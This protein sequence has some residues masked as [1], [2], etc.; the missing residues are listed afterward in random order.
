M[1]GLDIQFDG[2]VS[3]GGRGLGV[4]EHLCIP[5]F[6]EPTVKDGK[7]RGF[8]IAYMSVDEE[9]WSQSIRYQSAFVHTE[10][11]LKRTQSL[12][13]TVRPQHKFRLTDPID[14]P[15]NLFG[16]PFRITID[17]K[18]GRDGKDRNEMTG[19]NVASDTERKEFIDRLR[20]ATKREQLASEI[21]RVISD[22]NSHNAKRNDFQSNFHAPLITNDGDLEEYTTVGSFT[23]AEYAA[24]PKWIRILIPPASLAQTATAANTFSDGTGDDYEDGIPF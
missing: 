6:F 17:A 24:V 11:S 21:S 10:N 8:S 16:H 1:F 15:K 4:G 9:T 7:V 3:G 20:D 14:L 23:R 22:I 13:A 18:K 12:F 5:I 2:E 19:F